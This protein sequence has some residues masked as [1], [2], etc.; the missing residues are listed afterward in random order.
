MEG[1]GR[2]SDF[3]RV[4]NDNGHLRVCLLPP[5][6]AFLSQEQNGSMRAV[7]VVLTYKL[8][9]SLCGVLCALGFQL[10]ISF[11]FFLNIVF[12]ISENVLGR[13]K[14]QIPKPKVTSSNCI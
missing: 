10:M 13:K 14:K 11:Y 8:E 12:K 5:Y 6:H 4:T 7:A 2:V 9:R 1:Q 3:A